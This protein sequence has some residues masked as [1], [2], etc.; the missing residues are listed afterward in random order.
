[1]GNR[2]S[3]TSPGILSAPDELLLEPE[4]AV[5]NKQ[6][7]TAQSAPPDHPV[8][9]QLILHRSEKLD[10]VIFC[11]KKFTILRFILGPSLCNLNVR[12]F[13]QHQS[14]AVEEEQSAYEPAW[15]SRHSYE[16]WSFSDNAQMFADVQATVTGSFHYFFT[17]NGMSRPEDANGSGYF[18]VQPELMVGNLKANVPLCGI[19]CQT[20]LSKNLGP[21]SGWLERLLVARKTGYNT[22]HFTPLQVSDH[23]VYRY[24]FLCVVFMHYFNLNFYLH[25]VNVVNGGD[26]V[27]TLCVFKC[28]GVTS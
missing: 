28:S 21:F 2:Q 1:M 9:R 13:I 11:V 6:R 26:Y 7:C 19:V 17:V 14:I 24:C 4:A 12:L 16:F 10:D 8:I 18:I 5:I 27:L 20:V 15:H 23:F 3:H 22:I 25:Q